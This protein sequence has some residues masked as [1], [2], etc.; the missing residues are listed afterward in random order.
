MRRKSISE[1]DGQSACLRTF[2]DAN[3]ITLE[4]VRTP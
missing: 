4:I 3:K 1:L 2:A